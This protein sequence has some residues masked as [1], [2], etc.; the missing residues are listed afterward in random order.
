MKFKITILFLIFSQTLFCFVGEASTALME[1]VNSP[2]GKHFNRVLHIILENSDYEKSL[3]NL[4][5]ASLAK[6]GVLF[7]DYHAITHPSYPN[8]LA[9]MSGE[10]FGVLGDDQ[11]DIDAKSVADLLEA[12]K[13]TWR[14]YADDYP[15]SCFLGAVHKRYARKHVPFISFKH[16]QSDPKECAKMGSS[17][18]FQNDWSKNK[19]P[20]YGFFTPDLDHDGHDTGV[21]VS[22]KWL[23]SFLEPLLK[24]SEKMKGTLIV[25][26]YDE[27][28]GEPT[29]HIY[30]V[31][32]GPTVKSNFEYTQK[33]NHYD[34][35]RTIE[36]NFG[37]GTLGKK[38][39]SAHGIENIWK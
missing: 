21:K 20:E 28:G 19:M 37:L 32:V 17:D 36:D 23:K 11:I 10:T 26:T 2:V 12:K 31:F 1:S 8:Y 33:T 25:I 14:N 30:T 4:Y 16:V 29:N 38:D 5:L 35:L 3:E 27:A 18:D 39:A 34:V 22:S 7:T 6:K 15:G 9:M 24:D 13:L